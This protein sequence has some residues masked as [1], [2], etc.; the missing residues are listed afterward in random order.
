MADPVLQ[1][2][3]LRVEF[4]QKKDWREVVH[5]VSLD[6]GRGEVLALVGESG[7]GKSTIAMSVPGLLPRNGRN[8]GSILLDGQ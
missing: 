7:S 4:R 6:V 5:G 2:R 8:S 3:D 1:I